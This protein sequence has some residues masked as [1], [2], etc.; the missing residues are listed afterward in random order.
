[1]PSDHAPRPTVVIVEDDEALR[2]ALIFTLQLDGLRVIGLASGEALLTI[3]PPLAPA[4]LVLDQVLEG[5]SGLDALAA[6]RARGVALRAILITSHPSAAMRQRSLE[7]GAT[8]VE[9]PLL[10]DVLLTTI[11]HALEA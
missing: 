8:I 7:L 10:G 9:K 3:E 11:R 4:C 6:L 2:A 1:M 5:V